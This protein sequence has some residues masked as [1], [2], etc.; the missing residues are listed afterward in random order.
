MQELTVFPPPTLKPILTLC[1]ATL[2]NIGT[3]FSKF[4]PFFVFAVTVT[5]LMAVLSVWS[6]LPHYL[7]VILNVMNLCQNTL[8][9]LTAIINPGVVSTNERERWNQQLVECKK[10]RI[11]RR[12][13]SK[14]CNHCGV[15]IRGHDHHCPFIGKCVGMYNMLPF[16]GFVLMTPF[17]LVYN[18]IF[19][20][21]TLAM[22][23]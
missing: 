10:C 23:K 11:F 22:L 1:G 8:Y 3:Q 17:A 18:M 15:C 9:L 12:Y 21:A 7:K 4:L 14:H 13:S 19:L 16:M 6:N 5:V 20:I 2:F